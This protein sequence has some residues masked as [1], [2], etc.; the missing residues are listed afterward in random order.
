MTAPVVSVI[1]AAKNAEE[2]I[3]GSLKSLVNQRFTRDE[4]EVI[5]VNDGSTDDTAGVIDEF[6]E[7][8]NLVTIHNADSLGVSTARNTALEAATGSTI[9]YLDGDDWYAPGHLRSLTDAITGLGVDFVKTNYLIVNGFNRKLRNA[10]CFT[11]NTALSP[12]NYILPHDASTMVDF[13]ECWTGI[14]SRSMARRGLLEFNP[15]LRTCEDRP[16]TWR[17]HLEADSFAVVDTAGLCY[18]KGS[19]TSLTAIFDERQL[20]F[21]P[22]FRSVFAM[23]EEKPEFHRF[24]RK[25]V[26]NFLSIL[27]F[28]IHNRGSS[29]NHEVRSKLN[30]G[31]VNTL[32]GVDTDVIDQAL[33]NFGE[34]RLPVIDSIVRRAR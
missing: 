14:Y 13:P 27:Y 18:R 3:G 21:I 4:L 16:W 30:L 6:A 9:T 34:H 1:I 17:H 26:R 29:M 31:A 8:L 22:A 28:Q 5:V 10:P 20:D 19:A 24:E 2:T 33:R 11:H 12:R 23:L 32:N 15:D 7:Q 25:A